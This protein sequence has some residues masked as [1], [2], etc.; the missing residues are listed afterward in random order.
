M[1]TPHQFS[2][3]LH[4]VNHMTK[5]QFWDTHSVTR[6]SL[7]QLVD[8]A[9]NLESLRVLHIMCTFDHVVQLVIEHERQ[10]IPVLLQLVRENDPSLSVMAVWILNALQQKSTVIPVFHLDVLCVLGWYFEN[11]KLDTTL[12]YDEQSV[13]DLA[14]RTFEDWILPLLKMTLP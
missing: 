6:Q 9:D 2:Q 5:S 14:H 10:I 12:I 7:L 1:W 13:R 3:I 4:D 8:T 11:H